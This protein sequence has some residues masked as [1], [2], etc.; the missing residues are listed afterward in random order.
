MDI[1]KEDLWEAEE[2]HVIDYYDMPLFFITKVKKEK[3]LLNYYIEDDKQNNSDLW[4]IGEISED[5]LNQL[6]NG[7]ISSLALMDSMIE[8]EQLFYGTISYNKDNVSFELV[9]DGNLDPDALPQ[10]EFFIEKHTTDEK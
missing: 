1:T 4:F 5:E 9:T 2:L 8:K 3:I 10:D 6:M 7:E